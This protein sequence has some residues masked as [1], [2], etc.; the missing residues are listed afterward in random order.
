[1]PLRGCADHYVFPHEEY[2]LAGNDRKFYAYQINPAEPMHRCISRSLIQGDR[3]N[4]RT[5]IG[6]SLHPLSTLIAVRAAA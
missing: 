3:R 2:G 1:M 4:G 6:P 5:G